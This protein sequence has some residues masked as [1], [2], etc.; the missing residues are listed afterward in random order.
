MYTGGTIPS[1]PPITG[2]CAVNPPEEEEEET[3]TWGLKG[4]AV[5]VG[6]EELFVFDE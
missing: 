4:G 2:G 1:P 6:R 5:V 3:L